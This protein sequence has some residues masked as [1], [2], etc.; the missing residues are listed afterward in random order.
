MSILL[1]AKAGGRHLL[2][3]NE[4]I[5]R[6]ALEA[7]ISVA[8][9]YPGTPSS[10]IIECLAKV[11]KKRH[12]Y[13]EWSTNEKVAL[14]VAAAASF[15]GL[16]SLCVMKQNGVNVASDFLL[17]LAASGTRGGMVLVPCD[18]P[19]ALSSANEGESRH[20]S[21]LV[22]IPLL[23]PGDF[24]EAKDMIKW[25]FELSEEIHNLVMVRSV[26]RLSHASGNVVFD[27]LPDTEKAAYF[28]YDGTLLNPTQG[29]VFSLPV[30]LKHTLQQEK[31]RQAVFKFEKS[32]FNTYSGPQDPELLVISSSVCNLYSKEAIHLLGIE[33][34]VGLLKMGT[35]WP[36]PPGLMQKYLGLSD[37]ILIVEEVIPFLEENVKILC[38]ELAPQI[39]TKTFFGKKDGVI[40]TVGEMNPD[41]VIAALCKILNIE[42]E[43]IPEI[44]A[45]R[46]NELVACGAPGRELTF[47]A[48]CP[49]RASFWS[50]HHVLQMDNRHGFV[51][52]DIGCY[53]L[54]MLPTGFST[55]KTL[56]SMGS[57]SGIASG[58]GK[59]GEFGFDQPVLAVC[60]DSTFFHAV[61]PALVNAVHHQSDFTLVVLDNSGTAMTGFQPHPGL[62]IDAAGNEVPAI[63]VNRIC[64]AM[65]ALVKVCD[66]F[67]LQQTQKILFKLLEQKGIKVLVLRQICALSPEKKA[68]KKFEMFVDVPLCIGENCGC[69]QLCTRIF[70]CPGLIWNKEENASQIDEVICTG[71]G[72]CASICP[73]GAIKKKKVT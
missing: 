61:L 68:K 7:G 60:G 41:L 58:F 15:A 12:L 21:R 18:D 72:V 62:P 30:A 20:F 28:K 3:G 36:L 39:G 48:G 51:C 56:H 67:D 40:P 52:G 54:A 26:T 11:S 42:K 71:C 22:E 31:L 4:A 10:D 32:P 8:T 17:H 53:S 63:D 47:C 70:K 66:P 57:G 69:N 55:L 38:A 9:G 44:Y 2:M 33:D 23:E 29:P 16:R 45:R 37:N 6:G 35:T 27:G 14:E 5:A 73:S 25:A 13:V 19:G 46:A 1:E 49:H 59:L 34:R 50:I 64:R 24:Q 65:G 43:S